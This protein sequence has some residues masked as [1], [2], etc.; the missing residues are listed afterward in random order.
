MLKKSV[1]KVTVPVPKLPKLPA[2]GSI[3]WDVM[4]ISEKLDAINYAINEED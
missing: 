4:T 1:K 3:E 2:V